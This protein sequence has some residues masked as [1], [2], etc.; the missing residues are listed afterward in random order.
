[1]NQIIP[2]HNMPSWYKSLCRNVF[3]CAFDIICCPCI[4][5]I[6]VARMT[7]CP[8]LLRQDDDLLL[9]DREQAH[10]RLERGREA[11][12][13]RPLGP[14]RSRDL[15]KFATARQNEQKTCP[16]FNRLPAE[17]RTMIW[18]H[19]LGGQ[20]FH[21]MQV[22]KKVGYHR[23]EVG[24]SSDPGRSCCL[25]AMAY[26]RHEIGTISYRD[27]LDRY[28]GAPLPHAPSVE[29]FSLPPNSDPH[30]LALLRTCQRVYRE[31]INIPYHSNIFDIDDPETLLNLRQTIPR[32]RLSV[33]KHLRIFVETQH[34]PYSGM[35]SAPWY[36]SFD[37]IWT[38]MWH[39]IAYDMAG[40]EDLELIIQS[41]SMF[42][43]W[44][45]NDPPWCG[46]L[47]DVRGLK[48]FQLTVK[49]GQ[50][51]YSEESDENMKVLMEDLRQCMYKPRS[52]KSLT[53]G[54]EMP[55]VEVEAPLD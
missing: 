25:P 1:L 10:K 15:S 30:T 34:P 50:V 29:Q 33:I 52:M 8:N 40:L 27:Y 26:W 3:N 44:P 36:S 13:V 35:H 17:I 19:L 55:P 47:R 37:G 18:H 45:R 12:R 39:T 6:C 20:R 4:L 14:A 48:S 46:K 22:P 9:R 43:E 32:Q 49:E 51:A 38:L 31:T 2:L 11:R 23:C 54:A 41:G 21:L 42:P 7:C 16:L 53:E 24:K 28:P 5:C